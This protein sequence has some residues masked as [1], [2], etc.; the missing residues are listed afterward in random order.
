MKRNKWGFIATAAALLAV[1]ACPSLS[2]QTDVKEKPW[3]DKDWTQ[4]TASDC[5]EVLHSP[6]AIS[7]YR[8]STGLSSNSLGPLQASF[9]TKVQLRSALP[10]REALLRQLQL[11]KHYDK[12]KTQQ[13]L[14]FDNEH[15]SDLLDPSQVLVFI[16]NDSVE[17]GP[18]GGEYGSQDIIG[19]D[20]PRQAALRLSDGTQVLPIQV[21]KVKYSSM[22]LNEF[23]NQYEYAFPRTVRGRPLYT[24]A[25]SY[26]EVD[27][28]DPLVIDKKTGKVVPQDFHSSW[29]G[30]TFEVSALMYKGKLEY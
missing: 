30:F 24:T 12:M 23:S 7:R 29:F 19:P 18:G 4:W 16:E 2:G 13:R 14:A 25:D 15:E 10:I 27:L 9:N 20:A 8:T 22:A 17:P 5:R 1:A 26:V 3:V 28:G 11:D 6:W 21:D